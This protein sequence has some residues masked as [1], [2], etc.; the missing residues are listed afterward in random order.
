MVACSPDPITHILILAILA[1]LAHLLETVLWLV[2]EFDVVFWTEMEIVFI[3][4]VGI[5]IM[6]IVT[7]VLFDLSTHV[8]DITTVAVNVLTLLYKLTN[9]LFA[10]LKTISFHG[11]LR[12]CNMFVTKFM[13]GIFYKLYTLISFTTVL[14]AT[15]GNK[16]RAVMKINLAVMLNLV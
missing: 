12:N 4:I 1:F 14:R 9:L 10:L 16:V 5:G 6:L 7:I 2:N 3:V 8:L 15:F 11:R 13:N